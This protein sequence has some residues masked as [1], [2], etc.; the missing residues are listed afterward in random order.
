MPTLEAKLA[1]HIWNSRPEE[2]GMGVFSQKCIYCGEFAL[3]SGPTCPGPS[4]ER[5]GE[6]LRGE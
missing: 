5:S 1:E 3:Y 2:I 4:P 6:S